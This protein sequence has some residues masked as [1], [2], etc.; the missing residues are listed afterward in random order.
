MDLVERYLGAVR[1]NLP[2]GRADDIIA[3]LTDL[4]HARIEDRE[5]TLGRSLAKGEVSQLL[6]EFGHPL[7]VAGQYHEQRALIGAEIFPF[8]WFVLRI[9]LAVV[10]VIEAI[11]FGGRVIL[12]SQSIGQAIAQGAG[13]AF[14][15][16]LFQAAFVT[17]AFAIVERTGWLAS[18]LERWKPEE[19]PELPAPRLPHQRRP[20]AWEAAFSVAFSI[21]F[22]AW[23]SGSIE[24]SLIPRDSGVI[25]RGAPVWAGLYW[26]IVA[27]VWVS[28]VQSLVALL[29][30]DWRIARGALM[31]LSTVGTVWVAAVLHQAGR[32]VFVTATS[33]VAQAMRTQAS[34]DK[35]LEVAVIACAAFAIFHC[36][37]ELWKLYREKPVGR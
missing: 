33:D 19:L 14:E 27:L 28:I 34:L 4:I 29:R 35:A 12:G 32:I 26:P 36:A 15:T 22:L 13:Q 1:W 17:L 21:A 2:T 9:W 16:L 30:P 6:R 24:L 7:V 8:Y 11:E 23:W 31:L 25:V 10:A 3:E 18:Y 37:V 20:R 5:E